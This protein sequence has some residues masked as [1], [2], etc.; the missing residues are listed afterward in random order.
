MKNYQYW[1]IETLEFE[2]QKLLDYVAD[3]ERTLRETKSYLIVL[4]LT[5][6]IKRAKE[7]LHAIEAE[8]CYRKQF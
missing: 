2:K 8:L 3:W 6:S 5:H 7:K 4:S 1:S